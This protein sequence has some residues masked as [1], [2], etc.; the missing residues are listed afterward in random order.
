VDLRLIADTPAWQDRSH[1]VFIFF[2]R[3][4]IIVATRELS[5]MVDRHGLIELAALVVLPL[6][7]APRLTRRRFCFEQRAT[8]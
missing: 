8:T 6:T 2:V 7:A 1:G 3:E 4:A 5:L